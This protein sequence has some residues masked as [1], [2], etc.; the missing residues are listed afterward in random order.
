MIKSYTHD[1]RSRSLLISPP[2][3]CAGVGMQRLMWRSVVAMLLV[4]W[5]ERARA[6]DSFVRASTQGLYSTGQ[7]WM[8]KQCRDL[9]VSFMDREHTVML[10]F[11]GGGSTMYFSKFV[12]KLYT[13]ENVKAFTDDLRPK[14]ARYNRSNVVLRH[15]LPDKSIPTSGRRPID[16]PASPYLHILNAMK[17][18]DHFSD[19]DLRYRRGKEHFIAHAPP[20]G[21]TKGFPWVKKSSTGG[22]H[23]WCTTCFTKF[24][25]DWET[26][27]TYLRTI[28]EL[29][30]REFDIIMCDGQ[31]RA[32]CAFLAHSWL[33]PKGRVIIHDFYVAN[34]ANNFAAKWNPGALLR[35]YFVEAKLDQRHPYVSGGT[36][37]VLQKRDGAVHGRA[38]GNL[39]FASSWDLKQGVGL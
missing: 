12:R 21:T 1:W 27:G 22:K 17:G 6:V 9:L 37:V 10:E 8:S 36:V 34:N 26:H 31:A 19:T 4:L 18:S 32:A 14:L 25:G 33:A 5:P 3:P 38:G 16:A 35:M 28:E 13:I 15:V 2:K 23:G 39:P 7:P 11:G 24:K 29:G 30:P 20:D